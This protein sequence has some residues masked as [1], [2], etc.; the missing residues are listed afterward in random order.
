MRACAIVEGSG[1]T[2]SAMTSPA[3][4]NAPAASHGTTSVV[5]VEVL[6]GE[7][8]A[9]DERAEHGAE[10]RAE[11]DVGD[12]ARPALGRVH[13]GRGRARQQDDAA[14]AARERRGPAGRASMCRARSRRRERAADDA[15]EE[16][17]AMTGIRP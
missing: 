1:R 12:P 17:E 2:K 5:G 3:T 8:R 9:E 10:D 7:E 6:A 14:A 16:A 13:L 15:G 11:E 4:R